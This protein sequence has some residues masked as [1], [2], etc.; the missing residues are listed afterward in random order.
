VDLNTWLQATALSKFMLNWKWAWAIAEVLHYCGM[1]FMVGAVL[2]MDARL[3]GFFRRTISLH[4]IH[5]L[6]PWALA[7]FLINVI[8]GV[9]F[10]STRLDE[11]VSNPSFEFKIVCLA[12]A[13]INFLV[14][15]FVVRGR[16]LSLE[17]DSDTD[18]LAKSVGFSSVLLWSLV[19]WGGRMIP[20]YGA[21]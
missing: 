17:D 9:A 21:G 1:S 15:W 18:V 6:T 20:V 12:L 2:L 16:L 5:S 19:I 14:F 8:T 13:G 11:Y 3:M 4:Q 7:A 10:L